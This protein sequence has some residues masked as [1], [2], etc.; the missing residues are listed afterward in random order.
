MNL[1]ELSIKRPVFIICIVVSMLI[2]GV[3]SLFKMPVDLFPDVTFPTMFVHVAYPGASP[4]DVEKQISKPLE[5]ELSSL[6]GLKTITSNNLDSVAVIVLQ[7]KLGTDVKEAEQQVRN[8]IN[9]ARNKLPNDSKAPVIRR[10]DPADQAVITLAVVSKIDPGKLYD[11][12]DESIKPQIER[13]SDVGQVNIVGGRKQ[14]IHV[15]VNKKKMEDR[16][17][18][19]L[20]IAK[21]IEETSKDVPIGKIEN[22]KTETV[23][24]ALGEFNSLDQIKNVSVNFI[25]SDRAI[26]LHEVATVERSLE[27][28]K[29]SSSINGENALFLE[30]FK[31]SGSNTVTVTQ[32]VKKTME[33]V[34]R[35]LTDKKLDAKLILVRDSSIPIQLNIKDVTESILLG[36]LLC[37]VVVFFFLGSA[38]ST[39]ITGMALPNSLLGAFVIMYM[40]GFSIN[41]MTL[42]A[43]SLAVGLL[44]DDAIVVRE[45]IFRHLEM[46]KDPVTAALEG[47]KEVTLAVIA[48][49]FVV[50]AVFGPIAFVSGVVGQFF[51]QFGLTMVFAMLISL[52]DAFTMAPM[53]SAYLATPNEHQR[54]N[55][56]IARMLGAFDRFQTRLEVFYERALLY[57]LGNRKKIL[58]SALALF[59]VSMG[60]SAFV[61]KTFLPPNDI[62]EF[63]IQIEMPLGSSLNS[64]RDFMDKI[65]KDLSAEKS[66]DLLAKTVGSVDNESNK[67][68]FFV[69][70]VPKKKRQMNTTEFKDYIRTHLQTYAAEANTSV[71]DVDIGGG[72]LK[73]LNLYLTGENLDELAAYANAL[74]DEMKKI[75]GLVDIETNFRSG[76]PEFHVVFDRDKSESLGV[77]TT[78]AGAEL[79]ARTEGIESAVI[80]ENGI[81]YNVRLRFEEADRDLRTNFATT[82]VPNQNFNMIPLHRV[83]QGK[84][85]L[86]FSQINRQNKGRFIAIMANLGPGGNLGSITNEIENIIATKIKAPLG[87]SSGFVGQAED[88]KDLI[89]NMLIAMLLGVLFIYLVL[90]SLYESFITPLTILLALPLAISGAMIALLITGKSIDIFSMIGLVMLLGVVAKNSI[91]LVDYTSQ[92]VQ[93]GVERN[94]A[95]VKACRTRLRPILMTSLALISGITPIAIGITELGS[96]R[97]SMGIAIIGGVI[98]STLLTLLVVPA[99]YGYV[100]DFRFWL[101]P[102]VKNK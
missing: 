3:M 8:R 88:F 80:R 97:M 16:N 72:G 94:K 14:E 20:Q 53:M 50:V 52:F 71:T 46:G 69:R 79:R 29:R 90:S 6:S 13:I 51:R 38:R 54:G 22:K 37:V 48:T 34:N 25:G 93:Q 10:F 60:L 33:G 102:K 41:I 92:L 49:T 70:L 42:L 27:D 5:D 21:R 82:L 100:E 87:V 59:F 2:V 44:I 85:A 99:A 43:L 7:F 30:V 39:F 95:L 78:G 77:S 63:N 40:M 81:E 56:L 91:L 89:S 12:V 55:G 45:N 4:V 73:I 75:P 83:A 86:G 74:K 67:G 19:M 57:T 17:I 24:R 9:N 96:Q 101:R 65:E 15:L 76:K 36:I 61:P 35:Y 26:K 84:E 31:Q 62:G 32:A 11:V 47:T 66:I 1:A 98:S 23:M 58:F 68:S 28:Q 18:S 64:T